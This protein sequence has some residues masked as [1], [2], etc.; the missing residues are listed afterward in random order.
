MA[1]LN[2][3]QR[4]IKKEGVK[5]LKDLGIK[6]GQVIVDF[7]CNTGHYT[8]PAARIAGTEG[9][10]YAIDRE[11]TAIDQLMKSAQAEAL[12][13][14]IPVLSDK[15]VISLPADSVD[16]VLMYDVL[17]YL[18]IVERSQLY[19]S[20]N[21]ILKGNGILS[22]FPKH[23]RADLPRWNLEKLSVADIIKEVEEKNFL[24]IARHKKRIIHDDRLETG[25]ILNFKKSR[26]WT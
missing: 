21:T 4:W 17:H 5:Y 7:G 13:N 22:V 11:Q 9:K 25:V 2:D 15:A 8:L 20:A 14:I 18:N 26:A 10:V 23:N 16:A 6:K 1:F 12:G 3:V 19:R 24:I